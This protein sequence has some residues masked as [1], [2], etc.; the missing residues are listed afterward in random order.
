MTE[1]TT[2]PVPAKGLFARAIGV[3]FSPRATYAAVVAHPRPAGIL[4]LSSLLIGLAQG[5]PQFS[6]RGRQ[7]AI[8][9]N[10]Q[11]VEKFTGQK[12]TDDQYAA[13]ERRSVYGPYFAIGGAVVVAPIIVLIFAGLYFVAFNA[14]MG[15]TATFKQILAVVS[16]SQ[17]IGV[18]GA[19]V[20]A[21]IQFV[22]GTL[23]IGGP[24]NLGV[25]V[26]M[27]DET[28][29]I[30]RVLSST[31]IFTLWGIW[32]TGTGLGVLFKRSGTTISIVLLVIYFA[33]AG[34]LTA[35]FSSFTGR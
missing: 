29:L 23:S 1:P 33:I 32:N 14:L 31:P 15:G 17:V 8:N 25:L 24:F 4:L 2:A 22:Q 11:N 26:P 3:L 35:V 9:M 12:V 28:S 21:P 20:A 5:L 13:I 7:A 27:L 10:V 6:E 19:V 30:A 18:L 16:H 34:G